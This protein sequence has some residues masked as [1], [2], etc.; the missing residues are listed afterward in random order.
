MF[1]ESEHASFE[2]V[3]LL[4]DAHTSDSMAALEMDRLNPAFKLLTALCQQ[5]LSEAVHTLSESVVPV[6]H[7]KILLAWCKKQLPPPPS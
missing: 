1:S 2:D 3:C 6:W 4:L 5:Y 7:H